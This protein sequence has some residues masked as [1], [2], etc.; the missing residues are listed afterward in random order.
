MSGFIDRLPAHYKSFGLDTPQEHL[1]AVQAAIEGGL[2]NVSSQTIILS[3]RVSFGIATPAE[4][5]EFAESYRSD[6]LDLNGKDAELPL[7]AASVVAAATEEGR[8][9]APLAAMVMVTAGMGGLAATKFDVASFE[10]YRSILA[11]KQRQ[12]NPRP[13]PKGVKPVMKYAE[14]LEKLVPI[15]TENNLGS[16]YPELKKIIEGSFKFSEN[17]SS[18]AAK[19]LSDVATYLGKNQE[20]MDVHWWV[21]SNWC[22]WS[23]EY[24]SA[25]SPVDRAASAAKDLAVL[26]THSTHGIFPAQALLLRV[27]APMQ[28]DEFLP[29]KM[30]ITS[31][32]PE[33]RRNL[34]ASVENE[35]VSTKLLPMLLAVRESLEA[36]DAQDWE[37]RFKRLCGVDPEAKISLVDFSHQLY[38]EL[39][40]ERLL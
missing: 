32:K 2:E 21:L 12:T 18:T 27:M 17:V 25:M 28:E 37:P 8:G 3:A 4:L 29:I 30:V 22:N 35:S 7:I 34:L 11:N 19:Q 39:V 14:L 1:E 20:Q 40:L 38:L 33:I 13:S 26:S 9:S 15:S 23:D 31:L 24:F 6:S 5:D 16:L 10:Y 36:D